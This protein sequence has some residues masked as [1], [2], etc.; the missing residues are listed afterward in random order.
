MLELCD[1]FVSPSRF[2]ADRYVAWGLP[3]ERISVIRYAA[4]PDY[5]K[6]ITGTWMQMAYA[7]ISPVD[8][9]VQALCR[10]WPFGERRQP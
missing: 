1:R 6:G 9:D 4:H 5:F 8:L 3:R 2:L 7:G 10:Q